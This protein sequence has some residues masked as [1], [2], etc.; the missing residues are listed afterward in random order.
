MKLS[1]FSM[2]TYLVFVSLLCV[3]VSTLSASESSFNGL[4]I[5]N[6]GMVSYDEIV[7]R[8][9]EQHGGID[10][11]VLDTLRSSF[12]IADAD[13]DGFVSFEEYNSL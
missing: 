3:A 10:N 4:D 7:T 6:D 12:L 9:I 8:Y 2:M 13:D 5:N 1:A 11:S